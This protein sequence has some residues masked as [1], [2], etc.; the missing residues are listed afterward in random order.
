MDYAD[1]GDLIAAKVIE[2]FNKINTK[3]GKPVTRSNGVKEWTVLASVVALEGLKI[4][5]ITLATGVKALPDIVRKYSRGLIV[6]DMHAEILALRC[7]NLFLLQ[8]CSEDSK[9]LIKN[10]DMYKW[11][12]DIKLAL[13]ISEPPCGDASMGYLSKQAE[14]LT[15]WVERESGDT[16]RRKMN[17]GRAHFDQ[18]GIVRTK[19]GRLDSIETLSKSCSDKLCLKQLVG[20]NNSISS[21][22]IEPVFL[23][24]LVLR[25]DKFVTEDMS[26]CFD[27]RFPIPEAHKFSIIT[28]Q[29][30][31]Y[32]FHKREGYSPSP[33]SLIYIV[34]SKQLQVLNNGVKNGS[35]IKN[36]PPKAGGQS[37]ICNSSLCTLYKTLKSVPAS[38]Y[39]ELK[40]M[41]KS[42]IDAKQRG[43]TTLNHWVNTTE[44]N[45]QL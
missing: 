18:L 44:D 12:D 17:R 22:L 13:Y 27:T 23:D 31:T 43:K 11:N 7:F 26:R 40:N 2:A 3:S 9:Y 42:R 21:L 16:K 35:Y 34:E 39:E 10:G 38:D 19:P 4:F 32:P 41:Q 37:I 5:P 20:I 28:Y 25:Q 45:F 15:P 36:K 14:E 30:D 29:S 6:H 8:Q 24:F 1:Y 33:L